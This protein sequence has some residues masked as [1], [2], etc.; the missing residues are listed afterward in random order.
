MSVLNIS[1]TGGIASG[2]SA[3][4]QLFADLGAVLIDSDVL[5]RE[6]VEPGTPGLASIIERFGV[7]VLDENNAL[8]RVALGA[9]VFTDAQA[10]ADLNRIVHPAVLARRT[11]LIAGAP[12]GSILISVI[13][14]LVEGGLHRGFDQVIVVDVAPEIQLERLR[15]RNGLSEAE[16][17]DRIAAQTS[18]E[19][20]L[21]V[22][23]WIIDNS[24]SY[25]HLYD[26][27]HHIWRELTRLQAADV[28]LGPTPIRR[29][30][31]E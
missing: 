18:R 11:E 28:Q 15:A 2:K 20:R 6:V 27:V 14:L 29:E 16:A 23:D 26:Q 25:Q 10:R 17:L 1:L 12:D 21:A 8:D 30:C 19:E 7:S 3:V 5:A 9:V 22:A 13:P 31:T 24:G 4:A